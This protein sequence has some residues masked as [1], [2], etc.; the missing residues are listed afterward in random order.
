[1]DKIRSGKG[2][3]GLTREDRLK[4]TADTIRTRMEQGDARAEDLAAR[5]VELEASLAGESPPR[6][7]A[8]GDVDVAL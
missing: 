8:E 5:L 4:Q 3:D 7:P 1:V 6:E 2:V